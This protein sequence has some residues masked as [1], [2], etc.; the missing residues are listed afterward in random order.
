MIWLVEIT[1]IEKKNI[2]VNHLRSVAFGGV[3]VCIILTSIYI[4]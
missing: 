1:K 2:F 4:I 3:S